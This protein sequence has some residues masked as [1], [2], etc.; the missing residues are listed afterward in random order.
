M[1]AELSVLVDYEHF[2]RPPGVEKP[3]QL[4]ARIPDDWKRVSVLLRVGADLV[5]GL[6]PVTVYG[7]EEDLFRSVLADQIAER[8]VVVVRVR[9]ERGPKY[10]DDRSM[11]AL[12]FAQR[13][14]VALDG[15]CGEAR[16]GVSDLE[17]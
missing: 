7:Y 12:R 15:R 9:T 11:T 13:E 5:S 16:S 17:C 4:S 2:R 6:Q 3:G 1:V 14:R 8:V 10:Q